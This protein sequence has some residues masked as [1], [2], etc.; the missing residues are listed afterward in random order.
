LHDLCFH[1]RLAYVLSAD[2]SGCALD[3]THSSNKCAER[4]AA[5]THRVFAR[6]IANKSQ[7]RSLEVNGRQFER[8]CEG[9]RSKP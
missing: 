1:K 5:A 4:N 6:P 8:Y 7:E 2:K 3:R 9:H